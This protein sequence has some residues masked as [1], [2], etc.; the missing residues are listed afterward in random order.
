MKQIIIFLFFLFSKTLYAYPEMSRH[1]YFNC[2]TCH[3]SPSGGGALN[4]YGRELSKEV[5]STF[6]A[7]GEQYFAYN[8]IPELSKNEKLMV[9]AYVRG[10]QV[11]RDNNSVKEARTILMQ[12]DA[13]I[14]FNEKNWAILGTIGRQEIRNGQESEGHLFSRRHFFIYRFDKN[15]NLRLG[16]FQNYFGLSDPNHY[17]YVRKDLNFSYDMETYNVEYSLLSENYNLFLTIIKNWKTDNYFRNTENALSLNSSYKIFGKSKIGFSFYYGKDE[18]Q[19]REI[20][21]LWGIGTFT[22]NLFLMSELDFQNQKTFLN[23]VN[24]FGYVTSHRLTYEIYKGV[25]PFLSFDQKYLNHS[26]KN[27]ELHSFGIG[28]RL[29]PRPHFELTMSAQKEYRI[30]NSLKDNLYWVMGQFY[31]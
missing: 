15:Q 19:K 1:G 31:L 14:G 6:S 26:D 10:L 29:F 4:L 22:K 24:K 16:K 7:K 9:A 5:L 20:L 8:S 23:D 27:S 17:M 3:L 18:K 21:G 12:A 28:A 2:T 11:L 30:A 13:E 25:L